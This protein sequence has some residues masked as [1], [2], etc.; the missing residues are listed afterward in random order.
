MKEG[1]IKLPP[2]KVYTEDNDVDTF[3]RHSGAYCQKKIHVENCDN[4]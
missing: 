4:I 2:A 1:T 3:A